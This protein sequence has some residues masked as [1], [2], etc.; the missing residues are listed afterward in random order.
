MISSSQKKCGSPI[1][2]F[3]VT[4]A[5]LQTDQMALILAPSPEDIAQPGAHTTESEA[6][7]GHHHLD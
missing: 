2:G 7:A 1:Q 3:Q 5:I 4:N 6:T